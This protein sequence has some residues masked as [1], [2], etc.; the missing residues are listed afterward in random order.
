M[1]T[2]YLFTFTIA[3]S[4]VDLIMCIGKVVTRQNDL[5]LP[6]R[7]G[8]RKYYGTELPLPKANEYLN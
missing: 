1:P 8:L 5:A 2:L 4:P 7:S 3:Q 6:L